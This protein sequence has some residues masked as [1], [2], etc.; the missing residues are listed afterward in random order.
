MDPE[1]SSDLS[2]GDTF[3]NRYTP[4]YRIKLVRPSSQPGWWL[5]EPNVSHGKY[6]YD[7]QSIRDHFELDED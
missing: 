2:A 1:Q 5:V 7:E 3:R 6:V 4:H